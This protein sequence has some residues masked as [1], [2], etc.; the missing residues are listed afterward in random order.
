MKLLKRLQAPTPRVWKQL[1]N[2]LLAISTAISGYTMYSNLPTVALISMICGV[3]GKFLTAFF[4]DDN[5]QV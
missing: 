2:G 3:V 4:V 1:G 5:T